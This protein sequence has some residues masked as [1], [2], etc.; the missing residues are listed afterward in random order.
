MDKNS[1]NFSVDDV[2]KFAESPA[3]QQLI[4]L[5]QQSDSEAV[6]QAQAGNYEAAMKRLAGFLETEEAKQLLKNLG[7]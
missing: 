6:R 2:K 5:L 4:A 1:R 7:R 3:G